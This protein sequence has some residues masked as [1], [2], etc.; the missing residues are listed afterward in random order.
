MAIEN[1]PTEKGKDGARGLHKAT[2]AEER[3]VE[4]EKG[5]DLAKG[6]DRFDERSRSSDGKSAGEKQ[7]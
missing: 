5:S 3:K 1:A 2:R 4:A 7:R 6:A